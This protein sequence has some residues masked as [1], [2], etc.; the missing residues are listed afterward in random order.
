M[1]SFGEFELAFLISSATTTQLF[2]L[3][4]IE[5]HR[6]YLTPTQDLG[7]ETNRRRQTI[8]SGVVP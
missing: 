6:I 1:I 5:N 7:D 2:R 4:V 8:R 3:C